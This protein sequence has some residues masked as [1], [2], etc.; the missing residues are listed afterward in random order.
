VTVDGAGNVFIADPGNN[1]VVEVPASGAAEIA[2]GIGLTNPSGVALDGAGDVFIADT[3]N[4]RVVEVQ[5]VAVNFGSINICPAG[6]ASPAPCSAS[7]T[8]NYSVN[9]SVTLGSSVTVLTENVPVLDFTLSSTTCTGSQTSGGSCTAVISFA[10]RLPGLRRGAVLLM[11]SSGNLLSSTLIHGTGLGPAIAFGPGAQTTVGSTLSSPASIA[12]DGAGDVFIADSG[13]NRVVEVPASG[14]AQTTVGSGLSNPNGVAV[15]GAGDVFIADTG[16]SRVVEVRAGGGAQ[17]TVG[18]GLSSPNGVAVDGAGDVFIADTGNSRVVEVPAGGGA[19]TVVGSGLSNPRGVAV[20]AAGDVFIA[21][22]GA[23]QVVEVPAGG[24]APITIGSGLTNPSGVAVDAAGDVFI[25]DSGNNRLV[26][27]PAGGGA[28]T[29]VGSG[30]NN[31]G[32]VAV[33]AAGDVFIADT[34]NSR[35]VE[36]KRAQPPTLTFAPAVSGNTSSPQSVIVENIGNQVLNAV[37]PGLS[38]G[39]SFIQVAGSGTPADCT[40]SFSLT[41]G[42]S[43]NLSVSFTPQGTGAIQSVATFTDTSLNATAASQNVT[44]NGTGQLGPAITS[45]TAI[46]FTV[47]S[48]GSFS[49]TA[50]G[51]PAP[52]LSET[53]TLP[54]GVT[55]SA[56][57]LSG[58]PAANTGG[59]YPITITASNGVGSN[60]TQNFTLTINQGPAVTSAAATTF[61]VGNIGS[62]NPTASGFPAPTFSESGALPAGVTFAAGVLSGTPAAN[63]GGSYPITITASNGVGSNATQNFTLTINQVP[64]LKS[65]SATTFTVGSPGSF[66]VTASGF[67]APTFSETGTLPA[68]VTFAAGVLSGTP[69]PNTGGSYPITFTASN[70]VGSNATQSFT[71]TIN[72]AS[73]VTS[74]A[75]TT[76]TVGSLGSFTVT[77]SGFPTPTLNEIGTLPSGVTFSAGVLSGTPAANTGGSYPITITASNGVGSNATQSF[78]LTINQSPAVTSTAATTLTVGSLGSFTVTASGFPAPTFSETG[79]LPAGVTFSPA[80]VFSG[81]PAANTGGSYPITITA[82]NSVGSNAT[83]SFALTI[84]QAPAVTSAGVAIFTV[85]SP[86]S[87]TVTASGFPG[88]TFSESEALPG[89]VTFAAGVLSGTPAPNTAGNYNITITASN[90]VGSNATQSFALTV[91]QNL[92]ITS[93]AATTFTVGSSGSFTVTTSGFPGPAFSET[94]ALPA[95][96]TLSAGVLSGTPAANTAGN[97]NITIT[98]SNAVG[99][100]ATQSF[101][102]TINQAPIVTSAVGTTFTVGSLGSF[103]VTASGFPA[104]TFS[105]TGAL[106]AGVTF[107]AGVLSGIPAANT[108][109]NYP[110]T[111]IASNGVGSNGTQPFTLT[112]NQ[113]PAVTSA[114]AT[115]FTVAIPGSFTVTGSG[116][117]APTFS[118]SGALPAGVTLSPA[119]VLG[120]TAAANTGGSYPIAITASNGV[121]ANA[122]Q[123]FTLT[124]DQAPAVTS[125]AATTF[126]VG[127]SSSFPVTA[128]GFPAPSF[129]ETGT[130]PAG[131]TLAP[132]G[133]L[134]GT[135]TA[136]TGGT[137]SITIS[138]HNGIGSSANQD[139]TL[140]IGQALAITS[141]AKDTFNVGTVGSFQVT[142]SGFPTPTFS[143]TG[144][145]PVGMT[146]TPGG[147]LSGTPAA[148]TAGTYPITITASNG[149]ESN[150]TQNFTLTVGQAL[151]I[152][153]AGATTFTAGIPGSF[154]VTASGLPAPTFSKSGTLPAGVTFSTAGLLSGTP[155]ASSGG[156]YD[157]T[158]TATNGAGSSVIQDFTLTVSQTLVI[159]TAAKTTF[160]MGGPDSFQVKASGFPAPTFSET[161]TLPAGV[162]LSTAGLLSGTP[163]A[164]TKGNYPIIITASNG[165]GPNDNQGF[166]LTIGQA[167][168]MTSAAATMFTVG[169]LGSFTVTASGAPP[170][171]FNETGTLPAGVSFSPA[172]LLSGIPA[173]NTMGTYSISIAASNGATQKF[174]LTVG[175]PPAFTTGAQAA[176]MAG[177]ADSF[178]VKASGFPAPAFS[179]TGTLPTGV[180]FSPTGALSGTPALNTG[181]SYPITITASNGVGSNATQSFTLAINQA[182]AITST[183]SSVFTL[184]AAG[185]FSATATGFPAPAFSEAGTLPTGVSFSTAGVLSGIPA[186]NTTGNY[187]IAITASNSVGA[188]ATQNFI[189]TIGQALGITTGATATFIA[190]GADSFQVKATGFPAPTFNEAGTLPAGVTFSAGGLLSGTPGTNTGGKYPITITASNGLVSNATQSFTLTVNQAPIFTSLAATTFTVGVAGSFT[191]KASGLPA[192]TFSETGTLPAGVTFSAGVLSGT[193]AAN[194]GGTYPLTIVAANGV[195]PKVAQ[196]L[197]LTVWQTPT[198]NV[199]T[200][201]NNNWRDGLNS[202]ETTLTQA[203]VTP[204]T[205]GKICSTAAGSIDGQI[206]AQPL[207]ATGTIPGHNHVV[208]IGTMND[209]VYFI[210]GDSTDCAVINQISLLQ[211]QE[212]AV[213]CKNVGGKGCESLSP[214]IGIL[215]TPVIDTSTNTMYLVTWSESTAVGCPTNNSCFTHRLHA[216]DLTSGAEKF[217]GPVAI[218]SVTSGSSTFTS[219][220]HLQRPGLLLLPNVESNGDSAVYVALSSMDGSGIVGQSLPSGWMFSFDAQNLSAAPVAWSASPNGEGGGLWL[221]GAG[222]AA[223]ID[224]AGGSPYLFVPTG[225]GT[226]DAASGG[227]DFGESLVKL[228]TGLTV[229]DYFTPNRQYC[230]DIG[231]VDLGSGGV[232]LIPEGTGSNTVDFAIANG[233]DGNIYVTNRAN[234]GG[235]AGPAG[236]VCPAPG[237]P[238][239]NLQTI[240]ASPNKFYST[241]AFWNSNLYS[242]ANNS[243]LQKYQISATACAPGPICNTPLAVTQSDFNYGSSPVISSNGDTTGTAV[244]W[245]INGNGWP[246]ATT[247]VSPAQATLYGYDAEHV[248]APAIIPQLWNSRQCPK[249]DGAGYATK[250]TVPTVANGRVFIGTM[251][252][253][254]ATNTKGR[255]DVYGPTS[256]TCN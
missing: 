30:L 150:A 248:T 214:I 114:A 151:A 134:S 78:T 27:V 215:G 228:T 117:P 240:P 82:S 98:A 179:E 246:N 48:L 96:V 88:P 67:P 4:N 28:Q 41:A 118:E 217:N 204:S 136:K 124:I 94:G 1:E 60:A 189:L 190:G 71:L 242:V 38:V 142:A 195:G 230:D 186:A 74:A 10:P 180:S 198:T 169:S 219:Y 172:G 101:T 46:T 85:G 127:S 42:A 176:F 200:S 128:T 105:E 15:D 43:C 199:L 39:A 133:T 52:T 125:A 47:G 93:A 90:G 79:A 29:T 62:F 14:G 87:F 156:N 119:G 162:T 243:P 135:P 220:N 75:A 233:K 223:G 92:A 70:G 5:R 227:S 245:A 236:N 23:G 22:S 37:A 149:V 175:Q 226:F 89:G 148:N 183:A 251:D 193:P 247:K 171:T 159:T 91:A 201:R 72:Q 202:T 50:S 59:S 86:G 77:A 107:A 17:I 109:G 205:F 191:V 194:T 100:N 65:A 225:D 161:G 73:S 152:T 140:T 203:T 177:S 160:N 12:V 187:N 120:G 113:A 252:P 146:F 229:S 97:Y 154:T 110:M 76:F 210:D 108:A 26:E 66:T 237:G 116:F 11:D 84:N 212:V 166:T 83:Q 61:T 167:E 143:E 33:D 49:P 253:S 115:T 8:L 141:A 32:S 157:I 206:F 158:I 138:A 178:Q 207:V 196:T 256:S 45:A 222:V 139:F 21:N 130:L 9:A 182:P 36:V 173:P 13:N 137:Y 80:G 235:Y 250:F 6:H 241:A 126:T 99:P 106:P 147:T 184:G 192:P 188:N 51:F 153:S 129:S 249:R 95:G 224:Q 54:A 18:S 31:P 25:A 218:P 145:L 103:K 244:I 20:D 216:L 68:G 44:L 69:A 221:S 144:T 64:A 164:N 40:S 239:L 254:D 104:S 163:V 197:V 213:S 121:G 35:A 56:G 34:G 53:G 170:F 238:N 211:P 19:Q 111:I 81:T 63:T 131:V 185:S 55:F 181:G 168:A 7:L 58:T 231:D 123:S 16:N 174:T 57:V 112:I 24:G 3:G 208:Y 122:T 2:I 209:S 155:A 232:M 255:L 102:L 234:L 132:G 165:V